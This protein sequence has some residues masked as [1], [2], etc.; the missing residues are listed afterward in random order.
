MNK[1]F[2][3]ILFLVIAIAACSPR[4]QKIDGEVL[5]AKFGPQDLANLGG[6][7]M[8]RLQSSDRDWMKGKPRVAISDFR[9][10]TDKPGLNKQPFFDVIETAMWR[11]DKFDL[12]DHQET[13]ELIREA[14]FQQ[15]DMFDNNMAVQLGKAIRARYIMWGDISY[16]SDVDAGGRLIKQYRLSFKVTDVE[17][18]RIVYRDTEAASMKAVR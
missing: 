4:I 17:T 12:I 10:K 2:F 8:E 9:N 18:H 15:S 11:M 13:K 6:K 7:L 3:T 1:R 14:G 16:G 5:T